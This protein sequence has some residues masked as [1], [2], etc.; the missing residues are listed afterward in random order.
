VESCNFLNQPECLR[1]AVLPVEYR[2]RIIDE[3]QHW[4]DQHTVESETI[5]NIRNPNVAQQHIVQDLQSY[6]NYLKNQPDESHRLPHLVQFLKQL[7]GNR[8]NSILDYL[9]EYEQLFRA[10]G[11]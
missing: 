1:P 10:A 11:Y 7:E 6:V 9:P 5:I 4:I 3:L 2:Q 8:K